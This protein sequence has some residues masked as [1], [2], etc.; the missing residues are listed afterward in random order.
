MEVRRV[1]PRDID[2]QIDAP[3]YRVYFWKRPE[4]PRGGYLSSEYELREVAD[5]HEVLDWAEANRGD[6]TFTIYVLVD[7]TLV[8]LTG[9]D[10]TEP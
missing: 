2:G 3:T 1:D 5:V 8:K 4:E 10:P 9:N 6:S 7:K